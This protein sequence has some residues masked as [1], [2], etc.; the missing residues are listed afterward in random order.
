MNSFMNSI[1]VNL[2]SVPKIIL[3]QENQLEKQ[4]TK[5]ILESLLS[6]NQ[7][8]CNLK[9]LSDGEELIDEI[10]Q[11]RREGCKIKCIIIDENIKRL[12]GS[13]VIKLIREMEKEGK[14]KNI[15]IITMIS[16][17]DKNYVQKIIEAG[18]DFV[19]KKPVSKENVFNSFRKLNLI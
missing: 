14:I 19:L 11:D 3:V 6:E 15:K 18:A 10:N 2:K 8:L 17:D 13:E 16:Y 9:T 12:S 1:S 7:S 5:S 4:A